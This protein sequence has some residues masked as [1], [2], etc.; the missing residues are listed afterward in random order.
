MVF[1]GLN[2]SGGFGVQISTVLSTMH[3][4]LPKAVT[5]LGDFSYKANDWA[6]VALKV[7]TGFQPFI[8][9]DTE[10]VYNTGQVFANSPTFVF[11]D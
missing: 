8:G 11:S 9:G 2:Y 4:S 10:P 6:R 3:P 5:Q 1:L 7:A